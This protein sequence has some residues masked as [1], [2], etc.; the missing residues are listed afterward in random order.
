M[1]MQETTD[2]ARTPAGRCVLRN[3]EAPPW[4]GICLPWPPGAGQTDYWRGRG[5][6]LGVG[7]RARGSLK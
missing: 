4:H 1:K 7:G 3:K 2:A 5:N 6:R